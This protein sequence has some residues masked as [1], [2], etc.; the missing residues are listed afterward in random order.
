MLHITTDAYIVESIQ[1]EDVG[2]N[3]SYA[4]V[5]MA[6]QPS[7]NHFLSTKEVCQKFRQ[8]GTM[9]GIPNGY[10]KDDSQ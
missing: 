7:S 9:P 3:Q 1:N 8:T 5:H 4:T 6:N 2:F 10:I